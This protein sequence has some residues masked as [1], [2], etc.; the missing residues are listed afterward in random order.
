MSS[1]FTAET[2]RIRVTNRPHTH[3]QNTTNAQK[4]IYPPK[5]REI[6]VTFLQ[7]SSWK[8]IA[9]IQLTGNLIC[10]YGLQRKRLFPAW[11][12]NSTRVCRI[13]RQSLSRISFMVP[14]K[15]INNG[16]LTYKNSYHRS[17]RVQ[18]LPAW[19][20]RIKHSIGSANVAAGK[21]MSVT[22]NC[23]GFLVYANS[24]PTFWQVLKNTAW[25]FEELIPSQLI[26]MTKTSSGWNVNKPALAK[27]KVV[28][29]KSST[30]SKVSSI[31]QFAFLTWQIIYLDALLNDSW[32]KAMQISQIKRKWFLTLPIL[33]VT[34]ASFHCVTV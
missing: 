19:F 28:T 22:Q 1:A 9:M 24:P 8:E 20:V 13:I 16:L 2:E 23:N 32:T 34:K 33:Y 7:G 10:V 31:C 5:W 26:E 29:Y 11:D 3:I 21:L 12:I 6:K 25:A 18:K 15:H 4:K 27:S 17:N 14:L 30:V